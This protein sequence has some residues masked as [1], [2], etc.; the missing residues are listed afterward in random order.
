MFAVS[1]A[2]EGVA[3][4]IW[5]TTDCGTAWSSG[6]RSADSSS[7][8][9]SVSNCGRSA[10]VARRAARHACA[11]SRRAVQRASNQPNHSQRARRTRANKSA[12]GR[13][14]RRAGRW[15]WVVRG[16]ISTPVAERFDRLLRRK[17]TFSEGHAHK[18]SSASGAA[19]G[20]RRCSPAKGHNAKRKRPF[21]MTTVAHP[22]PTAC[23]VWSQ[24]G[25]RTRS[26]SRCEPPRLWGSNR[27]QPPPA[28]DLCARWA[29]EFD[30]TGL[31]S[32]SP[33]SWQEGVAP[34]SELELL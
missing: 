20:R 3:T 16:R 24:Q 21:K 28:S 25:P 7:L 10:G 13:A 19:G 18:T 9:S 12:P 17:L 26:S 6:I 2:L 15:A 1:S 5:R 31:S 14:T 34:V 4:S 32:I 22:S 27:L 30:V 33:T 8:G 23:G 11:R 29:R